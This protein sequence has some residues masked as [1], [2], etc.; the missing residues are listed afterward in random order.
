[1]VSCAG[2]T[3]GRVGSGSISDG[4]RGAVQCCAVH[5]RSA[6]VNSDVLVVPKLAWTA[7]VL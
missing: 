7:V 1:M 2:Q 5:R 6:E 4:P 3:S